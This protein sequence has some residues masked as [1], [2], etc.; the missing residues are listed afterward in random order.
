MSTSQHRGR[1]GPGRF[2][3]TLHKT[4]QYCKKIGGRT[5][6]FGTDKEQALQ[7]Y[8][9]QA[10]Y[11][12]LA[13]GRPARPADR[14]ISLGTLSRLYLDHQQSRALV[15]E[16]TG[17]HLYD[18]RLIL[19]ALLRFIGPKRPVTQIAT[20]QLQAYRQ[21]LIE[22]GHSANTINNH[23]ST[24]KAMY[25][26]AR[27][28]ELIEHL[29]RLR[30]V[31]KV[32]TP[33][34][35]KSTFNP[36]QIGRLLDHARPQ[37]KAMIWLGLNCGFGCTDCAELC[38]PDL[39]LQRGRVQLA[40]GKTGIGR[41]L[42]LWPET[43]AALKALPRRGDL[44]LATSRGNPWVRTKRRRAADGTLT[45]VKNDEVGKQFS[46]L[47]KKAGIQVPK[48]V[49]FYTLRRTAATLAAASGDAFAVQRLLGHCDL[50]MASCY[51]QDVSAQTDRVI[52]H[53]RQA[54]MTTG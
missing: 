6:Y 15:G 40:R 46:K 22:A 48:G 54:L 42:P 32:R 50:K 38:W 4:G 19:R 30:A 11:L 17:R 5:Y 27:D 37:M 29:P 51:V 10:A 35:Q 26:W 45:Y 13:G 41:N 49:G 20:L 1:T 8:L 12:H 47:I 2:P 18:Q 7:R 16:I 44:V 52:R 9:H 14:A 31:K 39:D 24:I 28:N 36:G 34:Q 43:I 3:L 25:H 33:R 23:L 21:R 53:S